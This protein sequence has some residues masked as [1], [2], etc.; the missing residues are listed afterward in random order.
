MAIKYDTVL[1][2]GIPRSGT[3]LCCHLLNKFENTLALHEPI[4]PNTLD[5]DPGKAVEAVTKFSQASRE[6]A[7][8]SS[9]VVSKQMGGSVPDN[10]VSR[11]DDGDGVRRES[12]LLGKVNVGKRVDDDLALIIK[13]NALFA[14]LIRPLQSQFRLYALVRNPL[15]VLASWRSVNLPVGHGRLPMGEAFDPKLSQVLNA[16]S[17]LLERQLVI[18]RWFFDRYRQLKD[19][20]VLSYEKLMSSDGAILSK[21]TPHRCDTPIRVSPQYKNS[22]LPHEEYRHLARTLIERNEIYEGFYSQAQISST[23]DEMLA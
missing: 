15:P 11:A 16:E 1:L 6:T 23:L 19:D 7:L 9:Y 12:V 20:Q 4:D 2:S 22:M 13:H 18:L 14:A 21:L 10:P 8:H 3:T 17:D 5:L